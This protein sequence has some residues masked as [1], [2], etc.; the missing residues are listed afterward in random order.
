MSQQKDIQLEISK[1]KNLP[2]LPEASIRIIT[3]VN[4]PDIAVEELVDVLSLSPVLVA[5]LLGLA[6]SAYFGRSGQ[7]SDL[8]IAIIQV[9][10]LNLVK[11][12][13]LSIVLNVE[14][15]TAECKMF[16]AGYFWSHALITALV[17]QK[18]AIQLN[19]ALIPSNIAYT[20]GLLLNIGLLAGITIYPKELSCIFSNIDPIE[21]SVSRAMQKD[22]GLNQYEIGEILL[23]RWKLP[24]IYQLVVKNFQ[25][26]EFEGEEGELIKLLE[27]S[28]WVAAYIIDDKM[29]EMTFFSDLVNELTL[30]NKDFL[31]IVDD[32][33]SKKD[34]I[35][36]LASVIGG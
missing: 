13:A 35:L 36:E 14:L 24:L 2:P 12:L 4:D 3:A 28:H 22:I 18:I 5:R 34:N 15:K 11:S 25:N 16:D 33:V 31:K 20:S 19:K 21:G 17:A 8:R 10:G 1:I 29:D 6:N 27:L 32:V 30:S 23:E 9:L 7:V 26:P